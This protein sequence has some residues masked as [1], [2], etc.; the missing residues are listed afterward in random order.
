[1]ID[2]E[3]KKRIIE[4]Y[5]KAILDIKKTFCDLGENGIE[6]T[7]PFT[8]KIWAL[9]D[10]Y[11]ALIE[12][13]ICNQNG[14]IEWFVW[15]CD[16]GNEPKTITINDEE[17]EIKTVDDLIWLMELDKLQANDATQH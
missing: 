10:Q 4:E 12:A 17:R 6:L 16:C 7:E 5:I 11:S 3:A 1:L 14:L 9:S 8:E 13:V 2:R 15:E